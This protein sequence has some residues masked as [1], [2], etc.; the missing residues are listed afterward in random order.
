M[1]I[2]A[3][4]YVKEEYLVFTEHIQDISGDNILKMIL[5]PITF[6]AECI[7]KILVNVSEDKVS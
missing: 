4:Y 1:K 7:H 5:I 2:L 6:R 3:S